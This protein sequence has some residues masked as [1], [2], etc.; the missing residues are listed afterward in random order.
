MFFDL[1][2]IQKI[3]KVNVFFCSLFDKNNTLVFVLLLSI[4]R[5]FS[6]DKQTFNVFLSSVGL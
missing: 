5:S 2:V 3:F 6:A 1:F 4:K